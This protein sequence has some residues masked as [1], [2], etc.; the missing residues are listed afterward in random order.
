MMATMSTV[1]QLVNRTQRQLLSGVVEERNKLASALTA[2]AT[3]VVFSYDIAAIRPGTTIEIDSE[4]LYVWEV[5]TGTKTATVERGFNGTT[6]AA[7]VSG[8]ICTVAPRFPR[9]QI[10]EA[11][12]DDLADLSAPMNGLYR[13]KTLDINYNGSDTMIN[14]PSLGDVIDLLD[15]RLRY[16]STDYPMIRRVSLVRN[17]PTSDFGSGTALKFN[18]PTRSG[19]LRV[20]Y[21]APFNR[22]VRESDDL[23]TSTGFPISAE[24]ILVLGAQIRLMAPREIKRNFTES[25]GDTRRAE[26]VPSGAV[27]NSIMQ[28]QRLRRDRIAAEAT[29]LDSQY[30]I[31]MN[32]D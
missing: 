5:V 28:L 12:N 8:S 11:F 2:T 30:P 23:Q 29:K 18:E 3:S 25:Q 31:Y 21:K 9:N 26:E 15:V 10:L 14:L 32:R 16:L 7:H 19:V 24:D 17:L 27:A 13:I 20:T 6:A 22:I 1:A 4:L